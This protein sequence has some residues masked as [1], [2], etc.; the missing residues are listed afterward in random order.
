MT[1]RKLNDILKAQN[2]TEEQKNGKVQLSES[3]DGRRKSRDHREYERLEFCKP[4][5]AVGQDNR[6]AIDELEEKGEIQ[7]QEED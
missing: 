6:A 4:G 1:K 3:S 7:Y 5:G 2:E